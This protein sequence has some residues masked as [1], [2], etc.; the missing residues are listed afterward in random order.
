[1]Q[2]QC[3]QVALTLAQ[4]QSMTILD[5]C[6]PLFKVTPIDAFMFAKWIPHKKFIALSTDPNWLESIYMKNSAVL[7][8]V[9]SDVSSK[10]STLSYY[11]QPWS[12]QEK[13]CK[14]MMDCLGFNGGVHLWKRRS[15]SL[16]LFSFAGLIKNDYSKL[17]IQ[18]IDDFKLFSNHFEKRAS[19]LIE[20]MENGTDCL[21]Q[22]SENILPQ[23]S[24][25]FQMFIHMTPIKYF[26]IMKDG[27]KH[28]ITYKQALCL[29]G[30]CE[31]KG[32]KEIAK[33]M[34]LSPR[35]IEKHIENAKLSLS[36]HHTEEMISIYKKSRETWV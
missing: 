12:L 16:Y 18:S 25:P 23:I 6:A 10:V 7:S 30:M 4:N 1:M 13:K 33:E 34:R 29:Q 22:Q 24:D 9:F 8:K 15:D 14:I 3:N 36:V 32:S 26:P 2:K 11:A 28:T 17:I 21:L 31:G 20:F 5:M 35:T 27:Q 19:G